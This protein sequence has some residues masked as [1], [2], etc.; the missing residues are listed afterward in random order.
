MLR[1]S[2]PRAL[3]TGRAERPALPDWTGTFPS[4]DLA[5]D[6]AL[7]DR[8]PAH[9]LQPEDLGLTPRNLAYVI[10]TSGSTGSPKGVMVEHRSLLN[11]IHWHC[12]RLE[13]QAGH[14]SSALAGFGFDAATWELWP[15]LCAGARVLLPSPEVAADPQA[16]LAWWQRQNL[17]VSFLPTPLAEFAFTRGI[18][19]PHLRT[20]LVGGDRLRQLPAEFQGVSLINNNGPT[21]NTVVA[22]S[23]AIESPV[24][25]LHIGRPIANTRTYILDASCQPSPVGVPGEIYLAGAGLARGYLDRPELTSERFVAD[26]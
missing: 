23:G 18:A 24:D 7:W 16:L 3:L 6:A 22:T 25:C 2:V 4:L 20:L 13:L 21:E 14:R 26:P 17:D 11:L 15:P 5:A 12:H 9:N 19:N 1:D 10:Y 8:H